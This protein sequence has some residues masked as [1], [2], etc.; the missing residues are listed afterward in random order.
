MRGLMKELVAGT[1]DSPEEIIQSSLEMTEDTY[2]DFEALRPYAGT[3][4]QEVVQDRLA[5]EAGWP[6]TTDCNRLDQAFEALEASGI[7]CRQN[8]SCCGTCASSEIGEEIDEQIDIGRKVRG[9]AHYH[10]QDTEAAAQGH[11]LYLSYGSGERGDEAAIDI[12][13]EVVAILEAHH[14]KVRWNGQLSQRIY[15]PLDWKRR[16]PPELANFRAD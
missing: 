9:C 13:K 14:F 2:T 5:E 12:G 4:L 8:F 16:L 6:D 7:I 15:I 10:M 1:F 3:M 11:G